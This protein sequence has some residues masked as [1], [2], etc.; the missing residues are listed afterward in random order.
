MKEFKDN[1]EKDPLEQLFR[2]R[3]DDFEI[4]YR[5]DDWRALESR[6]DLLDAKAAYRFKIRAISAAA[7]ILVLLF[8]YFTF[9]NYN[10]INELS[11]RIAESSQANGAIDETIQENNAGQPDHPNTDNGE[12]DAH[13]IAESDLNNLAD[14]TA[15][16]DDDPQRMQ[17][18]PGELMNGEDK[19]GNSVNREMFTSHTTYNR[20]PI[21]AEFNRSYGMKQFETPIE[22]F[23]AFSPAV[24][25]NL[26]PLYTYQ[27]DGNEDEHTSVKPPEATGIS[28]G[29][30]LSPDATGAGSVSGFRNPGY[31]AG[32]VI[33]YAITDAFSV[34][35]GIIQT[36]VRYRAPTSQY[37]P[38]YYWPGGSTPEE[39]VATCL[40]FDIPL[41]LKYNLIAFS[42]SRLY[43]TV[44]ISSYI[45]QN[46][47]YQFRYANS[48]TGGP[49]G[50]RGKTG[51]GYWFSN[52]GFSAGYEYD[53]NE[54]WAL[55][56]EPFIR[57]PI[58]EV[59][60]G[61]AKLYS[62]G[63]FISLNY[64]L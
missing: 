56:A 47:D 13:G 3:A 26:P 12:T 9:N 24:T 6:L 19:T 27:D 52:A 22:Y 2:D 11:D 10:R 40:M 37:N 45:M 41:S 64:R 49:E 36:E 18:R 32:A 38:S 14:L 4:E 8:S 34:S 42:R 33:E 17:T 15:R 63:S 55:R 50:W 23:D 44:S 1:P 5:E 30:A 35:V 46:E 7:V 20:I 29:L 54:N 62:I 39:I 60:W 28:V 57:L 25:E 31:K 21:A 43:G 48:S 58:S 59:G 61:N 51:K 53:L 16:P